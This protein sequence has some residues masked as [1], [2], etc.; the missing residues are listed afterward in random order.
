MPQQGRLVDWNDARGFGFIRAEEGERVF[1]HVSAIRHLGRR[2]EIG[3]TMRFVTGFSS[4]G[5]IE[6]KSVQILGATA[7]PP[8][9]RQEVSRA[10][11]SLGWRLQAVLVI[12]ALLAAA[13]ALGRLPIAFAVAYGV[14][15]VVSLVLYDMDKRAAVSGRWRV[16]EATLLGMDFC[17]GLPGGLLGQ[18]LFRHKTRKRSYVVATLLILLAHLALL[19]AIATGLLDIENAVVA[20]AS[21]LRSGA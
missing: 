21:L 14:M 8:T 13:I 7:D 2:P 3:D 1:I 20:M 16:S 6:A 11:A 9:R 19:A 17:F 15:S 12:A 4:S 5:R 10:R 18:A